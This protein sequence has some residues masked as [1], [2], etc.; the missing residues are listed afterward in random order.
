MLTKE[1]KKAGK[2]CLGC[3]ACEAVCKSHA[4]QL[5]WQP[6][7]KFQIS[8]DEK[9]CK[10][11]FM[12]EA[13]CPQLYSQKDNLQ[14]PECKV[15]SEF[16][17]NNVISSI[18]L[19]FLSHGDYVCAPVWGNNFQELSY[20]LISDYEE[21]ENISWQVPIYV[22]PHDIYKRVKKLLQEGK[23]VAFLGVPCQVAALRN[24]LDESGENLLTV[25]FP[26]QGIVV[27]G[28]FQKHMREICGGKKIKNISFGYPGKEIS[29]P[30]AV[31]ERS[32][33][34]W[35]AW[36]ET[37]QISFS[38][39]TSYLGTAESD[40]F[41][42]GWHEKL[43]VFPGCTE[44]IFSQLPQ[45]SDI[46]ICNLSGMNFGQKD[47]RLAVQIILNNKRGNE[48]VEELENKANARG[49]PVYDVHSN[50][51]ESFLHCKPEK[52]PA[53][54][55]FLDMCESHSLAKST[56]CALRGLYDIALIGPIH[57]PDYGLQL[58]YYAMYK[59][60][61]ELD[62]ET[63]LVA[64][65]RDWYEKTNLFGSE[66]V[67]SYDIAFLEECSS[68]LN[69]K[70][71]CFIV[72]PG[73][74]WDEKIMKAAASSTYVLDNVEPYKGRLTYGSTIGD[75]IKNDSP[76]K[77]IWQKAMKSFDDVL[78][79]TDADVQAL[80]REK[81]PAAKVLSPLLM[82]R[83]KELQALT[84]KSS[85]LAEGEYLFSYLVKPE[86]N[87]SELEEVSD[88]LNLPLVSMVSAEAEARE[89][90]GNYEKG[91]K[92]ED[93]LKCLQGASLVVTDSPQAVYVALLFEKDFSFIQGW[94]H[95]SAEVKEAVA[96]LKA[97][98]LGGRIVDMMSDIQDEMLC[99]EKI[100]YN[101]VNNVMNEM[102]NESLDKLDS[103]LRKNPAW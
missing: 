30:I 65:K 36:P 92:L 95:Q 88:F 59:V 39:G 55:R 10:D 76:S 47:I 58:S 84:A 101:S 100:E 68:Q 7:E 1:L 51:T 82:C 90:L 38:D 26:C 67:P 29:G 34:Y 64:D 49:I 81:I 43:N 62:Y 87:A 37:L 40:T 93:W 56:I 50:K 9:R 80:A 11:C 57:W 91:R 97:L 13:V 22:C 28:I 85:V 45:Q 19:E 73:P 44:C 12:C 15:I 83:S 103:C 79:A 3:G 20:K 66:A 69:A 24:V 23:R 74:V 5:R 21:I 52:H 2:E 16:S 35:Q 48:L 33:H 61:K 89:W 6:E 53:Q 25:S 63:L 75:F 96:I 14:K 102:R 41:L 8:V 27:A 60:L 72:G 77:K 4:L 98:G 70:V 78:V 18:F 46:T 32:M 31:C 17:T 42:K 99:R 94:H 71:S 54:K 86:E